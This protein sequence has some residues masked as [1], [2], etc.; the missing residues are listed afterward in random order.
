[1]IMMVGVSIKALD[2]HAQAG[3]LRE[4]GEEKMHEQIVGFLAFLVFIGVVSL[5][6][7]LK[8]PLLGDG[9]QEILEL[10]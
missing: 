8:L 1:M 4:L 10:A 6:V 7:W 5:H 3:A 2:K 9:L